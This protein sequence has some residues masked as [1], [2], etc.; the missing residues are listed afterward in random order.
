MC[1]YKDYMSTPEP[2]PPEFETEDEY[3]TWCEREQDASERSEWEYDNTYQPL[4]DRTP[5]IGL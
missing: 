4:A 3:D 2:C 5:H 1:L